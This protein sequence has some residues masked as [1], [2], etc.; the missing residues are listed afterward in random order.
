LSP[1]QLN[2]VQH[3]ARSV[4]PEFR[5]YFLTVVADHLAGECADGAVAKAVDIGLRWA[6][7]RAN[8]GARY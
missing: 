3:A 8:G 6:G 4:A 7:H 2:Y 1:R 5:D